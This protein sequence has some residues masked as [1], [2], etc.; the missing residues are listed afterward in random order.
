LGENINIIETADTPLDASKEGDP[1]VKV[2]KTKYMF[3][4]RHQTTGQK[5]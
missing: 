2:G 5:S 4:P 1:E 3:M